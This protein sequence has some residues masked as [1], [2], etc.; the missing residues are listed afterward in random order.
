MWPGSGTRKTHGARGRSSVMP[1]N[2]ILTIQTSWLPDPGFTERGREA[3]AKKSA[4]F[5]L[6][7]TRRAAN[8][9]KTFWRHSFDTTFTGTVRSR[10]G[11][12]ARFRQV[13]TPDIHTQR[14]RRQKPSQRIFIC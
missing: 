7:D 10:L 9:V 3:R 2:M 4:S 12:P 5:L 13:P 6:A 1:K 8:F 14:G 11:R